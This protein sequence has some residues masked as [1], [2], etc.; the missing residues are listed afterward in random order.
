MLQYITV[1]GDLLVSEMAEKATITSLYETQA[2]L[3]EKISVMEEGV[4]LMIKT[5]CHLLGS[6]APS[7]LKKIVQDWED[8]VHAGEV[9]IKPPTK[10]FFVFCIV[11][12]VL[13]S[14]LNRLRGR[15]VVVLAFRKLK[16]TKLKKDSQKPRKTEPTRTSSTMASLKSRRAKRR[17][18]GMSPKRRRRRNLRSQRPSM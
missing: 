14:T 18:R 3:A 4:F 9:V 16:Q 7:K 8:V 13:S 1:E 2:K 17:L 11:E 15:Q 6:E 5:F 10:V 12:K